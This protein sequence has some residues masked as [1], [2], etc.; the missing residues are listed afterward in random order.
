MKKL[1]FLSLIMLLISCSKGTEVS[2]PTDIIVTGTA[3]VAEQSVTACG[4]LHLDASIRNTCQFGILYSKD[5]NFQKDIS[6]LKNSV[7]LDSDN[8]F[9]V[10]LDEISSDTEYFYK[11]FLKYKS[12]SYQYGK[13][14]TFKTAV[15]ERQAVAVDL[16]LSVFWAAFNVGA[17][18]PEEYGGYYQWGGL[19]DVN[20]TSMDLGWYNCPH[21]N[22][23]HQEESGWTKY[24]PSNMPFYWSGPGSPDNKKVLD[25]EDDIAHVKYGGKWRMP[26]TAEFEE[27]INGCT[28]EWTTLHGINGQKFT[29]KK[30]GNSIFL[31]AA[32]FCAHDSLWMDDK[33]CMLWNSSLDTYR[34]SFAFLTSLNHPS[35]SKS[36]C[37]HYGLSVRPVSE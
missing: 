17:N 15:F 31:P 28:S 13:V 34:P 35:K 7:E 23:R 27:L 14:M 37:R 8:R 30:N 29:S 10:T 32:G 4:Y 36:A 26:T 11:A 33:C 2:N 18:N 9:E 20:S 25:P 6:I 16:G 3:E 19:E 5:K 21:H 12:G 24:I 1:V 22:T